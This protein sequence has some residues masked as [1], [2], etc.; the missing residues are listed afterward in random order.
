MVFKLDQS[1][2]CDSDQATTAEWLVTNGIGGYAAGTVSGVLTRRYHAL[3]V[4][5]L[6]PPVGR[7]ALL[8]KF[9]ETAHIGGESYD[10]FGNIWNSDR[11]AAIGGCAYLED[12]HLEG[13]TPV[14]QYTFGGVR[15]RKRI[16][17]R[18][19]RNATY[20]QYTI[21][22]A[23]GP[24][25]LDVKALINYRDHHF[26]ARAADW[27]MSIEPVT[28]GLRIEAFE[29][30]MPYFLLSDRA[31]VTPQHTWYL[32]YWLREE[33]YRGMDEL[34]DHLYGGH[35]HTELH[36]GESMTIVAA[37][38]PEIEL[39]GAAAYPEYQARLDDL[40]NK[41][42]L[43]DAPEEVQ[44]LVLAADQFIVRRLAGDIPDGRSVIAGYHW[45]TDWG[46]DTMIA[47]PGLTLATHREDEAKRI[48]RTFAQSVSQGMLPNRFPDAGQA[49]EYNTSDA[50][51]WYFEAIN[52]TFEATRDVELIRDLYPRLREIILA[53]ER[54]TRHGIRVDPE[55]G[56]LFAGEEGFNLT[57]MDAKFED[58]VV[59][60]R[61]GK[62]VE[63]NALWY[64][65]LRH[66]ADFARLLGELDAD[67]YDSA[68][69]KAL[70]HFDRFW[71]PERG[72]CYD[73][74]D[75][76]SGEHDASLR[77][78][79]L[80]AISLTHSPLKPEHQKAVV[81]ACTEHLLTPVGL[82]SI[83]PDDPHYIGVYGGDLFKRDAAYHQGTVWGWLIGPYAAAHY[84]VYK[85]ADKARAS[86]QGLL[87]SLGQH[88]CIGSINE[89]FD[90]NAPH[91]PRG[92][93]AQAWSV[94][95]V[96]RLW[97]LL[98]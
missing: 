23:P 52:A 27:Y 89:I 48:L 33:A 87:T 53:H 91:T 9:D 5:A 19:G 67:E 50:T 36:P 41:A 7:T 61:T 13:Q 18:Y 78:N 62:A 72:Y 14:W 15:L 74:I 71:N 69:E 3:L 76:P 4:A 98:S 31:E 81:D 11:D 79:Q 96:L 94:A 29:D 58:W 6:K 95:E 56:L 47:L 63:I 65:A 73:V 12:F 17:M 40:I 25:T 90:G 68:A 44:H 26:N 46:R 24:V 84:R 16:W 57:W 42:K 55:D 21:L 49:P 93:V 82:R 8:T 59:T 30:A 51:L 28:H 80:F 38:D 1:Q 77:P 66:M 85:D 43:S 75:T 88:D 35:L 70:R 34:A 64:N 2:L 37:T 54:G 20:I 39:S 97:R 45:F 86:L 83:A 10:L 32:D 60:P 92:A 22:D